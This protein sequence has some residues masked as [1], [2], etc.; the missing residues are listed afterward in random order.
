MKKLDIPYI[1]VCSTPR[2][3]MCTIEQ[4]KTCYNSKRIVDEYKLPTVIKNIKDN[5]KLK[6]P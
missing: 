6:H 5:I 2:D 3:C 4:Q 1:Y